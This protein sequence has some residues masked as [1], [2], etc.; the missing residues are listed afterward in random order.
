[1][2]MFVVSQGTGVVSHVK[3]AVLW[4]EVLAGD[5]CKP[6]P[7]AWFRQAISNANHRGLTV[8]AL[9][10]L[11]VLQTQTQHNQSRDMAK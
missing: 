4:S 6:K 2:T 3:S 7:R 1:M 9:K 8:V 11:P 10:N 5:R